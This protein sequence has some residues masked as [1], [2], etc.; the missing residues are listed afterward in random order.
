MSFK[1]L[2]AFFIMT[3]A[4]VC[5]PALAQDE[6]P[7]VP[8]QPESNQPEKTFKLL[9]NS[10]YADSDLD[11]SDEEKE[12]WIPGIKGGTIEISFALGSLG[13]NSVFLEHDQIIYKYTEEDTY[14]GDTKLTGQNAFNPFMRLG[15]NISPWLCLEGIAGASFS[16]YSQSIENSSWRSNEPG[17][18]PYPTEPA[19]GEFDMEIRSMF[20]A[21]LGIN[22]TVYFLNMDGDG[23][24]RLHPYATGGI[25][26]MW[27]SMN[28]NYVDDPATAIDLNL[29]GGLRF[30]ADK[31][32][33][34]RFEVLYHLNSVEFTPSDRF[35][36]LNEGTVV[37]PLDEFIT[38]DEGINQT[39]V[40]EFSS[41]TIGS[42][43][44][45]IGLQGSF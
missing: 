33:S 25:S 39:P 13:L 18:I 41:Q 32:I 42:L 27:Y 23:G 11:I 4:L 28:S 14:W 10:G 15:Y 16:E 36:D 3:L 21:N 45:S 2:V 38:N 29:G 31:N 43:G 5:L 1:S 8:D 22:A 35:T 34:I 17:S 30:L 26:N 19:I 44:I 6:T 24:G 9:H 40:Q 37:I 7:E 12:I 20:T